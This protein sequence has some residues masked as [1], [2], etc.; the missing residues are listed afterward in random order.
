LLGV[1]DDPAVCAASERTL[2]C[3]RRRRSGVGGARIGAGRT[4]IDSLT[5][6]EHA[7]Y[8]AIGVAALDDKGTAYVS[9]G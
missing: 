4:R 9:V 7:E 2:G 1:D 6:Q 5:E 3:A 8:R